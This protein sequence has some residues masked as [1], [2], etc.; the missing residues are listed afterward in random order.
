MSKDV[1]SVV[2]IDPS[3]TGTAVCVLRR[4]GT[5]E[6]KRLTSP[7]ASGLVDRINRFTKLIDGVYDALYMLDDPVV[8]IEGYSMGSKGRALTDICEY[9]GLLRRTLLTQLTIQERAPP[10]VEVAPS[11]LKKFV[12][13]KGNADKMAVA[14][15]VAKRWGVEFKT[16]D[17]FDAYGL[18]RMAGCAAGFWEPETEAQR[19]VMKKLGV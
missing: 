1:D 12:T 4:D 11:A 7:P 16:N 17:E 14:L 15:A 6:M 2:G 10:P 18:A 3:L 5:Y 8:F 13:S 9:G 19:D